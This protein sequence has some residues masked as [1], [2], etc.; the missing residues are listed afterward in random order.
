M[1][2]LRVSGLVPAAKFIRYDASECVAKY[3]L[4]INTGVGYKLLAASIVIVPCKYAAVIEIKLKLP[5][6]VY[7]SRV[8][9]KR[10][11]LLQTFF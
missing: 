1:A 11:L 4:C 6:S 8:Q 9:I 2:V 5:M 7:S 3:Q 10:L